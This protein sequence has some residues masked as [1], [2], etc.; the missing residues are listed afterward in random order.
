[1]AGVRVAVTGMGVV[2]PVGIGVE[3]FWRE[4]CAGTCGVGPLTRFEADRFDVRHGAEVK[5]FTCPPSLEPCGAGADLATQF[6]MVA[7]GEAIAMSGLAPAAEAGWG[8][9]IVLA[10]NF[11]GLATAQ[12]VLGQNPSPGAAWACALPEL[13]FQAALDR[14]GGAWGIRG[15]RIGLSMS[16][17][18][19]AAAVGYGLD[20][21]R[22][23]RARVVIAGGYDALS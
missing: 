3:T 7:A 19:G 20:L 4:L 23:G 1:M 9:A 14:I 11:G 21:L 17:A 16:C 10:T 8:M 12:P 6:V 13:S 5:G 18:S 15:P 2:S 22:T